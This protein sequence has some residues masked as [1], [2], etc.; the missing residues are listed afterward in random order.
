MI[1]LDQAF[2]HCPKFPTA[3]LIKRLGPYLST[4]VAV[5]SFNSAKDRSL[6]ELLPHQQTNLKQAHL[7]AIINLLMIIEFFRINIYL[8][9]LFQTKGQFLIL[10]SLVRHSTN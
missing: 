2:A 6:G 4:N 8:V 5:Q 7:L 3:G 10:Y 9:I 1:L